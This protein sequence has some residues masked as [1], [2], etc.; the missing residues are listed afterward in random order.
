[1]NM[2]CSSVSAVAGNIV[3]MNFITRWPVRGCDAFNVG[4]YSSF[5]YDLL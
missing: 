2:V 1:M 4:F 3:I 5:A